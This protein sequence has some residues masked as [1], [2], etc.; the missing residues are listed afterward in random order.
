MKR[1]QYDN[2]GLPML[3]SGHK[4]FDKQTQTIASGQIVSNTQISYW[5]RPES[6]EKNLDWFDSHKP[7][8]YCYWNFVR[9][10]V[11]NA[12]R[13][14]GESHVLYQFHYRPKGRYDDSPKRIFGWVLTETDGTFIR[15]FT[16][17]NRQQTYHVI[18]SIL[19]YVAEL[20]P[21]LSYLSEL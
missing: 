21:R 10:M 15:I 2:R 18:Q 6:I 9:K 4:G 14:S 17:D 3:Q 8:T 20:P 19:P 5:I 11:G 16:A 13:E 7:G 12:V 1:M